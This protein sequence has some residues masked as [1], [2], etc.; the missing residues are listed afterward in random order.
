MLKL[1]HEGLGEMFY[2][3]RASAGFDICANAGVKIA[4][5]E[6]AVIPTGLRI[7]ESMNLE[8]LSLGGFQVSLLPELQ[9]RPRSGLAAK[10]GV[11]VLNAPSTIDADYRG[12][13][14]VTL[15][16]QGTIVFAVHPGDRIAQGICAVVFH[17]PGVPVRDIE[18]GEGGFGSTGG[19]VT[20]T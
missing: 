13:I 12:E 1:H 6:W 15:I 10:C 2:A 18:R 8:T 19:S 9:I 17:A 3:T 14:K 5:G 20:L 4:P 7:V 11:T 16:N